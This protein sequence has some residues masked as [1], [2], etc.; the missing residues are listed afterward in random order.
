MGYLSFLAYVSEL[1]EELKEGD[2]SL[3][4]QAVIRREMEE[5]LT[6]AQKVR[7][8][9]RFLDCGL[10]EESFLEEINPH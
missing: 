6:V 1:E 2:L 8:I 5:I 7:I 4:V 9:D 10:T 3:E